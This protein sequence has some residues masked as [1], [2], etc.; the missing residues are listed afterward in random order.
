MSEFRLG[1]TGTGTRERPGTRGGTMRGPTGMGTFDASTGM[2]GGWPLFASVLL[3]LAGA[4]NLIYGIAT[5]RDFSVVYINT[6]AGTNV[7]YADN[8]FW[9]WLMVA[10]GAALL[11]IS[12]GVYMG[13]ATARML[14]I[15]LLAMNAIGQLA[16]LYAFPFWSLVIIGLDI[17]A[18]YALTA[19]S[20]ATSGGP[21]AYEPYPD[22]RTG[23]VRAGTGQRDTVGAGVGAGPGR[24][25]AGTGQETTTGPTGPTGG[26][27]RSRD[28]RGTGGTS[29]EA[30]DIRDSREVRDF[31]A[32]RGTSGRPEPGTGG[33]L[34]REP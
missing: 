15:V 18:I 19:K 13:N 12:A 30:R 26:P 16:F 28:D 32:P 33:D 11:V 9:G 8:M 2:R 29:S 34:P 1:D 4:H 17:L 24:G 7:L 31:R 6:A 3:F 25:A 27:M 20:H 14:G 23:A 10:L 5:L 22:D 21:G